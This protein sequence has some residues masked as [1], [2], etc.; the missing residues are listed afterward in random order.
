MVMMS[1]SGQSQSIIVRYVEQMN[2]IGQRGHRKCSLSLTWT[3]AERG[4]WR[5]IDSYE[6]KYS[7]LEKNIQ[8]V[9]YLVRDTIMYRLH[10]ETLTS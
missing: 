6:M 4:V 5:S 3:K 8:N 1:R 9:Q 7:V 10:L 2:Q